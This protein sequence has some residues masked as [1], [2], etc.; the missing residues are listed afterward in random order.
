MSTEIPVTYVPARNT[1]FLSY[2][3]AFAEVIHASDIFIGVNAVDY[4]GYPDCRPE[5]I[6]AFQATANLA[7]KAAVEGQP[8]RIHAPLI[9]MTK[10]EIIRTGTSLGVDYGL[11]ISCYDPDAKGGACGHCDS[12]QL[13]RAGFLAARVDDVT[14]YTK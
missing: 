6:A 9:Q 5:F 13:R 2:A 11:T 7:T 1:I 14:K 4:S 10:A 12:C 8:I 3:L